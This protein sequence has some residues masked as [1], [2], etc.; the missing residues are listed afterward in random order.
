MP[1]LIK[2]QLQVFGEI[3]MSILKWALH[4]NILVIPMVNTAIASEKGLLPNEKLNGKA[5]QLDIIQE[6]K[7]NSL[8]SVFKLSDSGYTQTFHPYDGGV[9]VHSS[10][11]ITTKTKKE[12]VL[13]GWK[14]KCGLWKFPIKEKVD[15]DNTYTLLIDL[16]TPQDEIHNVYELASTV[17]AVRYLHAAL[18]FPTKSTMLK[19][20]QNKWLLSLPSI[21]ASV[22]NEFFQSHKIHRRSILSSRDRDSGQQNQKLHRMIN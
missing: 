6:L 15:N 11:Y 1:Q 12:A 20:I 13:Q 9:T 16:P 5:R 18:G 14:N 3:K 7:H 10:E 2:Q 19:A 4:K 8:L 22:V 17:E 21:T